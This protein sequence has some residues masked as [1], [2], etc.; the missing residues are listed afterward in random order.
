MAKRSQRRKFDDLTAAD[1]M[2]RL[3]GYNA[4]PM[5][6]VRKLHKNIRMELYNILQ[7]ALTYEDY[8]S[9]E[10]ISESF[11]GTEKQIFGDINY[12]TRNAIYNMLNQKGVTETKKYYYDAIDKGRLK[13]LTDKRRL[14]E[15][16][17]FYTVMDSI[18]FYMFK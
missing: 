3:V 5:E 8:N 17:Q 13:T 14:R 15:L 1:V 9:A 4:N 7:N 11:K 12:Q 18:D 10:V 6:Q 16:I 2:R